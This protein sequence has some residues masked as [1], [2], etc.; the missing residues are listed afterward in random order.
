MNALTTSTDWRRLAANP[1][2]GSRLLLTLGALLLYRLARFVP[3]PGIDA[4]AASEIFSRGLLGRMSA[5]NVEA[6]LS[7]VA[8]AFTPFLTAWVLVEFIRGFTGDW[9]AA[10]LRLLLMAAMAA[11]QAYGIATAMMGIRGLVDEPGLGFVASTMAT[12]V[13]STLCLVW[14]GDQITRRGLGNGIWVLIAGE[15]AAQLPAIIAGVDALLRTGS[16]DVGI[17]AGWLVISIA[18]SAGIVFFELARR[19]IPLVW[20]GQKAD[21][22]PRA[23]PA[24][25]QLPLDRVTIL[26][27]YATAIL[28][29][30]LPV[31]GWFIPGLGRVFFGSTA[32]FMLAVPLFVLL[33]FLITA[34]VASPLDDARKLR[35]DGKAIVGVPLD[36][37]TLHLDR[38]VTRLTWTTALYLLAIVALP[39]LSVLV[40]RLPFEIGG[41]G[42][43]IGVIVALGI[44]RQ[45]AG[46]AGE[47]PERI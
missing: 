1:E 10:R 16:V 32:Y 18:A 40:F 7:I 21:A 46:L 6:R 27:A 38:I 23:E 44:L 28:V 4:Q 33:T 43:L 26:P 31:L 8:L 13:A 2:F 36:E 39:F 15:S 37:T 29:G 35:K 17:V 42:L 25:L 34:L 11:F 3:L 14:L 24:P 12:L 9:L 47:P 41:M 20:I 19:Q 45:M 22:I 5:G 30:L